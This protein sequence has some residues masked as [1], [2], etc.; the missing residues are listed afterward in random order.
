MRIDLNSDLG[1]ASTPEQ[2]KCEE[3]LMR[4]ITSANIACGFHAGDPISIDRTV[5]LA[6]KYGVAV[7]AHPSYPD[8]VGFGR[9]SMK[10]STEEIELCILYQLG[11]LATIAHRQG[12][13]IKHVKPHGAL[14]ND[15]AKDM[16]IARAVARAIANFDPE[17]ILVG[18]AGSCILEA[19]RKEGLRVA[20]EAFADRAYNADGSLR[21][22]TLKG[23]LIVDPQKASQQA[24]SIVLDKRVTSFEG[25]KLPVEAQTIC[26][27]GDTPNAVVIARAVR[28]SLNEV[29][30]EVAPLHTFL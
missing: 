21:S 25:Q 22:R 5:R 16:R 4:L 10:L 9:T 29:G 17:L 23:A 20:A 7:G 19:G 24:L 13:K 27:H 18:L 6:K 11:A 26:I 8:R 2:L 30:I 15:A 3:A 14:Y 1:E 28:K 12:V